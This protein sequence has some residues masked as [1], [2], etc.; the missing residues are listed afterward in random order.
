MN[1]LKVGDIVNSGKFLAAHWQKN[2]FGLHPA[3]M[4]IKAE[5]NQAVDLL[6]KPD[7]EI[8][9][10]GDCKWKKATVRQ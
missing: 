8:E 7:D 2:H 5:T 6:V 10:L 4:M 9:Y 1:E 3:G